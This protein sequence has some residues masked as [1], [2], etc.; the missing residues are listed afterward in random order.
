[1]YPSISLG[2]GWGWVGWGVG[3][4]GALAQNSFAMQYNRGKNN[5]ILNHREVHH[6]YYFY[7]MSIGFQ[8]C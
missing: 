6:V 5:G 1:M 4:G 2:R 3:G 7:Q 8:Y